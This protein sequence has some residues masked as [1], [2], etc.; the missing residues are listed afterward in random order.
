[1]GNGNIKQDN[2]EENIKNNNKNQDI[3][4]QQKEQQQEEEQQEDNKN[5]NG[6]QCEDII[7]DIQ[8]RY[9]R[10][11][12]VESIPLEF[13]KIT[14]IVLYAPPDF[15]L[16]PIANY[17]SCRINRPLIK[18]DECVKDLK[19]G[20]LFPTD[21][22]QER[23]TLESHENLIIQSISSRLQNSD[24]SKGFVLQSYPETI[25]QLLNL[26]QILKKMKAKVI[27][28]FF[29]IDSETMR[30]LRSKWDRW[31]APSTGKSYHILTN[32][33]KKMIETGNEKKSPQPEFMIDDDTGEQ[34]VQ[35]EGDSPQY[36][37]KKFQLYQLQEIPL[38]SHFA[39]H[40]VYI[41]ACTSTSE[42]QRE[43]TKVLC[44]LVS[45][46]TEYKSHAIPTSNLGLNNSRNQPFVQRVTEYIRQASS[47]SV[48]SKNINNDYNDNKSD[49][50]GDDDDES[51]HEEHK[52]SFN[53]TKP[54]NAKRF[55]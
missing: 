13:H 48:D 24:C 47:V 14:V 30:T 54:S 3:K 22:K 40:A 15:N 12:I 16:S 32:P 18:P 52:K 41:S 33:P 49:D 45:K 8:S 37:Q 31:V 36:Y 2:K 23:E 29:E 38:Y 27:P 5:N 53:Q 50:D 11:K 28:F 9:L 17:I 43:V 42:T 21:T 26:K 34:L 39:K 46:R 55:T 35:L 1:M 51:D 20:P 6:S 4:Q 7:D 19:T 44:N 10:L 25:K